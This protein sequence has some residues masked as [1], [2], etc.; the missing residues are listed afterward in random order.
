M[1]YYDVRSIYLCLRFLRHRISGKYSI[2]LSLDTFRPFDAKGPRRFDFTLKSIRG[3]KLGW[4]FINILSD[5]MVHFVNFLNK[6][7]G[8]KILSQK[9]LHGRMVF[10]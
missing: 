2:E 4:V 1:R 9:F 10:L 6:S 5:Q 3:I 7:S 8:L